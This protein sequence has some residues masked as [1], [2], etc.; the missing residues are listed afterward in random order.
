M[1]PL[2]FSKQHF[3]RALLWLSRSTQDISGNPSV[4]RRKLNSQ[5]ADVGIATLEPLE[6]QLREARRGGTQRRSLGWGAREGLL[7]H[8]WSVE[9]TQRRRLLQGCSKSL[10]RVLLPSPLS[11]L[12]LMH[13]LFPSYLHCVGS[14]G[15]S[16]Q[17]RTKGRKGKSHY[18]LQPTFPW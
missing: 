12:G 14:T 16:R 10:P 4:L 8:F 13:T 9:S 1:K 2:A 18:C 7:W 15:A 17:D 11:C 6:T 5:R 3:F